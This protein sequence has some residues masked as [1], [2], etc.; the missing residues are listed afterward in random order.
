MKALSSG[1]VALCCLLSAPGVY[2][3][4]TEIYLSPS[5]SGSE[6]QV[7]VLIDT[8]GSMLW[9]EEEEYNGRYVKACDDVENRRINQLKE[10][11][12]NVV[13]SLG[14]GISMGV[15]RYR[16]TGSG[17]GL[18]SGIGGYVMREVEQ[19]DNL[20]NTQ[21]LHA[22]E[23]EYGDIVEDASGNLQA[24]NETI[25]FPNGG[26]AGGQVGLFFPAVDVPR[27]A[28]IERAVLEVD[29]SE[30]ATSPL[31]LEGSYDV[32]DL[33]A[34]F[35][36]LDT[37]SD[38][39][40][41]NGFS[42]SVTEAWERRDTRELVDVTSLLQAATSRPSWCGGQGLAL[43]FR[44]Q[45]PNNS[46]EIYAY[47][48]RNGNAPRLRI[49]WGIN[50][51]LA[52][53]GG[54]S[55]G[56][57]YRDQLSC[58]QGMAYALESV[59]DDAW[60]S[61]Q[62][63]VETDSSSLPVQQSRLAGW[64]FAAIPF[65]PRASNAEPDVIEKAVL[66]FRGAK[67]ATQLTEVEQCWGRWCW[68]ETQEQPDY[69]NVTL[70]FRAEQG[71]SDPFQTNSGNISARSTGSS[72]TY[73]TEGADGE[74]DGPGV[75][76][77]VDVTS[78][79][80]EAM[81]SPAWQAN[82]RLV[83]TVSADKDVRLA[84]VES[85]QANGASLVITA[86]SASQ[87]NYGERVRD[88]L[89]RMVNNIS[90]NGGTPLMEAYTEMAKY[91]MG[92]N[93]VFARG[94]PDAVGF[95]QRGVYQTPL[96]S[97]AGQCSSNHI[98]LMTDGQP[99]GDTS[100]GQVTSTTGEG[101]NCASG[102]QGG[103]PE[104]SFACM[105]QLAS[106]LYDGTENTKKSAV[107]THTV[108]FHLDP[109]TAAQLAEVA[110]A[111]QGSALTAASATELESAL[112]QIINS[113]SDVNS[114]VAAP[115]VAVNQL[116]RMQHLDQ[117][118]YAIFGPEMDSRW[119]GNLKR[120][121]LSLGNDAPELV[122]QDGRPA[123]D[124]NTGFFAENARSY[125]SQNA[126]GPEVEMGGARSLLNS[127]DRKLFVAGSGNGDDIGSA[128][129]TSGSSSS[130]ALIEDPDDLA[131][132]AY[133]LDANAS[134]EQRNLLFSKLM[135]SWGDPLHSEPRLVNYGYQGDLDSA[136][137]DP[138]KQDNVLFVSTNDGMLHA[139]DAQ[140]GKEYFT[141]MP[142]EQAAM[143]AERY[144]QPPLDADNNRTT[145]GLD[146]S[147]M[148]WR[149]P[150]PNNL[151][152][153]DRVYLYGGMRRGGRNYY[154]LD[155]SNKTTPRWLWR[156]RGGS[157]DFVEMGQTWSTPTLGQVMLDDKAV[158]VLIFGGG[159]S[160]FDHDVQG[161]FSAGG[162]IMGN[163]IYVVNA[164]T[165]G[166]IWKVTSGSSSGGLTRDSHSDMKWSI[167]GAIS[168]VDINFDGFTDYL[169]AADLGGQVFRVDL[170]NQ[171][172]GASD[173]VKRVVTLA[174]LGDGAG[175][176]AGRRRFYEAPAITLG[177]KNKD[178]ML[179]VALGS[180][181]RAH[182]LDTEADEHFFVLDDTS[183]LANKEPSEVITDS[184]LLDVTSNVSPEQSQLDGK[185]GWLIEL[186]GEGEKVLS[187][188]AIIQNTI[189]F[190]TYLPDTGS[191]K[192]TCTVQSKARLYGISAIDGSP[193]GLD[194]NNDGTVTDRYTESTQEGLP[195][196]PQVLILPPSS[197][198]GGGGDGG[199]GGGSG[200]TC[201]DGGSLVV[202]S[203][204]SVHDGGELKGCPLQKTRWYEVDPAKGKAVIDGP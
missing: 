125:W 187:S 106:W 136:R 70:T 154:A 74:F 86:L 15:G 72:V 149:Q 144:S 203:G 51:S 168:A 25:D 164:Y 112:R 178:W 5:L 132:V 169:Y 57:V 98:I 188:P 21:V 79:V 48:S 159:Y 19:L 186:T 75:I 184:D 124:P 104:A 142:A 66:R 117:L 179:R 95:D 33:N 163:A 140:S 161:E 26:Q 139:L 64:R 39:A 76:H 45:A 56:Q 101:G 55:D 109:V 30:D 146:G 40:W 81:S 38:R 170:N 176:D 135:E 153:V 63:L 171:N 167:P 41:S 110:D 120:Y 6:A 201:G 162:D 90:P 202:L 11:F 193:Q 194:G 128:L 165:G 182:P 60:E 62:G 52:V 42:S 4:D 35:T 34:P 107:Q 113:I 196:T 122:D 114:T 130:I 158:P 185:S 32:S 61:P 2:A 78:L 16:Q 121:R 157:G 80:S 37:V 138:D 85:G 155:V 115:G 129:A 73:V 31:Q 166:L 126:D 173:L 105:K 44:S 93:V 84:A 172:G 68:T 131:K 156:I 77:E 151:T 22:V 43:R 143:A 134:D 103:T 198:D 50:E 152:K 10:A 150:D 100:Y 91:M 177:Q 14:G 9:C 192:Q 133:G 111:G 191:L 123:V 96:D 17:N 141:F 67:G 82:G 1:L 190:T 174:K 49:T 83:L 71:T 58:N 29:P 183:A 137:N 47:G 23:D 180:G 36:A 116:N 189:Y 97:N 46:R 145:Y 65:D 7:M 69:G 147:W 119:E 3:D 28:V 195:S 181:Y 148:A 8:S 24:T 18:G 102:I 200:G 197:G 204:T 127:D 88:D 94:E 13:D 199:D 20:V 89:K 160:S 108:G 53:V 87:S 99:S 54:P 27:Y 59:N 118:Y 92:Q 12:S 175:G